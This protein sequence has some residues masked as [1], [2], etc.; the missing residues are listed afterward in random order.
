[1]KPQLIS[2]LPNA[3]AILPKSRRA[4]GYTAPNTSPIKKIMVLS[5]H[6]QDATSYYRA[7]GPFM[8]MRVNGWD[9][10]MPRGGNDGIDWTNI[11]EQ[12]IVFIQRPYLQEHVKLAEIV[13]GLGRALWIDYDDW[14]LRIP[15]SN[16]AY[17]TYQNPDIRTSIKRCIELAH[18]ITVSTHALKR[19]LE[20]Y[21]P[22]QEKKVVVVPNAWNDY[23]HRWNK[24]PFQLH[25]RIF[26]RGSATHNEDIET[27]LDSIAEIAKKLPEWE[28]E[29][30]GQPSFRV[31]SVISQ[32]KFRY[33]PTVAIYK[34]FAYLRNTLEA[35][36][37]IVPLANSV[38]N[39]CKSNI[40]WQE[41]TCGGSSVVAPK[42]DEWEM[43]GITHYGFDHGRS[44][45]DACLEAVENSEMNYNMSWEVLSQERRL[46]KINAHRLRIM[47][48]LS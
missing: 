16:P 36:V 27:H 7:A 37:T 11:I 2:N 32:D 18:V 25:K 8:C 30:V 47:E 20:K 44:F 24:K 1:M 31:A 41:A 34:Y 46:S 38:F 42:W 33:M 6:H 19:E 21:I 48:A 15:F 26:W 43:G 4:F 10:N 9:I 35:S 5:P 12:D 29:F 28:W 22:G 40:A 17:M 14:V 23:I 39:E 13:V 45:V 3:G